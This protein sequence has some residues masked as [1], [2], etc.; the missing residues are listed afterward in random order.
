MGLM[1]RWMMCLALAGIML[2]AVPS[3]W[4]EEAAKP[5]AAATKAAGPQDLLDAVPVEAWGFVAIPD[6][7]KFDGKIGMLAEQLGFPV[8]SPIALLMGQLGIADGLRSKAGLGLVILDPMEYG[9]PPDDMAVLVPTTDAG[10]LLEVF[11]PQK[12]ED[13]TMK[14]D[15][16]GQAL[17]AVPKG[18][19]VVMGTDKASVK[20][21]AKAPKGIKGSLKSDQIDRS[22]KSDLYAMLNLRPA[23]EMARPLV[24]QVVAM[25]MMDSMDGNPDAAEQIQ[26]STQEIV[27]LVDQINALELALGLDEAGIQ[28][29]AFLT[30]KEDGEIAK[31]IQSSKLPP[32]PMLAGLPSQPYIVA[33]GLKRA[34]G[35]EPSGIQKMLMDLAMSQSQL[36]EMIDKQ[37][38]AAIQKIGDL[39]MRKMT[40][41][42]MAVTLLPEGSSG[43][44]ALTEVIETSDPKGMTEAVLKAVEMYKGLFKDETA[45]AMMEAVSCKVDAEQLAGSSVS[46][47]TFDF[48]KAAQAM[49]ELA[50]A[51]ATVDGIFG[52]EGILV[53]VG[54]VG[55]KHVVVTLG[56][57]A[58][59][60]ETVAGNVKAG[61]T[62]LYENKGIEKVRA[63]M[64]KNRFFEMFLAVDELLKAIQ[65]LTGSAEIPPM[66]KIDGPLGVCL[67]AEKNYGRLDIVVPI[68][69][70]I[71]IKNVA[72]EA[73]FGGGFGG[74]ATEPSF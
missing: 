71:E 1:K 29:S 17:F 51:S 41:M 15:L 12:D 48:D 27:D 10:A 63:K 3:A 25:L 53:R 42:G 39:V 33:M 2:A 60:F 46:H 23:I 55:D 59:Q 69:L 35:Q 49:P 14:I 38:L 5:K 54:P 37:Q 45:K 70:L 64:P 65:A 58:K 66:S 36:G 4:A 47:I 24:G 68:E 72:L 21:V 43:A 57:G 56:G 52:P 18:G 28:L 67:S 9:M 74:G 62:P 6:L 26:K 30:F 40:N 50:Q 13:G 16:M 32:T 22:K 8:G 19:F 31:S 34:E 7:D 73:M 11:E 20:F 44:A 61:K